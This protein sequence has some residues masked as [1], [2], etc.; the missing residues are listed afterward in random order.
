M[1]RAQIHR[2]NDFD[3]PRWAAPSMQ[4]QFHYP[5]RY[6]D[7]RG[8]YRLSIALEAPAI[9]WGK[10]GRFWA[11]LHDFTPEAYDRILEDCRQA[12]HG[13]RGDFGRPFGRGG[14]E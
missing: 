1:S 5:V 2:S 6:R 3:R 10:D 7:I 11:F 12:T 8:P 4:A 14:E 9:V 13:R